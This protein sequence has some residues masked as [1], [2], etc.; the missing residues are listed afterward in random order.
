[1]SPVP[2]DEAAR[3]VPIIAGLAIGTAAKYALSM[4]DGSK[5]TAKAI[6]IDVLLQGVL[7][8]IAT[9]IGDGAGATG[10]ARVMVAAMVA[11][12]SDRIVRSFL[13][14]FMSKNAPPTPSA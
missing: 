6:I 1:M 13:V 4:L 9:T 14:R 12:S 2:P 7:F 11:L 8:V 10:N 3:L 5:V